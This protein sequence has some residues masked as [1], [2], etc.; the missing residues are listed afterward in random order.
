LLIL[1]GLAGPWDV[2]GKLELQPQACL[3]QSRVVVV[4]LKEVSMCRSESRGAMIQEITVG[5][6]MVEEDTN[7]DNMVVP[8][9]QVR[10][11]PAGVVDQVQG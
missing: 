11:K 5:K 1:H 3:Q 8:Y 7:G 6:T 10:S 9:N 2:G 4:V